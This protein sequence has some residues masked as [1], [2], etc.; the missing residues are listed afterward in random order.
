SRNESSTLVDPPASCR[1]AP[2]CF[3]P[4]ARCRSEVPRLAPAAGSGGEHR[5]ACFNYAPIDSP[6]LDAGAV[7]QPAAATDS[8]AEQ[9][10]QTDVSRRAARPLL[11]YAARAFG[12]SL[13][14]LLAASMLIFTAIQSSGGQGPIFTGYLTFV[15]HLLTGNFGMD[16]G[17]PI[18]TLLASSGI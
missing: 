4:V 13:L 1:F 7:A 9:N 12:T 2:V 8:A 15:G 5:L 6:G 18:S 11:V 3:R 10:A 16:G 17:Y 14:V